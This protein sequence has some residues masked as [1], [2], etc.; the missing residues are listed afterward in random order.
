[1]AVLADNERA[2]VATDCMVEASQLRETTAALKADYRS[3]A[4]SLDQ[5]CSDNAAA[6]NSAIPQPARANLTQKE[7]ARIFREVLRRRYL[8]GL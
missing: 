5:Y 6:I 2:A 1:M 8:G 3:C 7:K 4:N